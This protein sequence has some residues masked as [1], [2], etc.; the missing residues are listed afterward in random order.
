MTESTLYW[1]TR[2][3]QIRGFL[4]GLHVATAVL[5][6][7]GIVAVLLSLGFMAVAK[8]QCGDDWKDDDD[9]KSIRAVFKI[10]CAVAIPSVVLATLCALACAFTPTTREMVVIKVIPAIASSEQASKIV[11]LS[12]DAINLASEWIKNIARDVKKSQAGNEFENGY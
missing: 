3:D 8:V 9:Y 7:V 5:A 10:A 11:D 4:D 1:I 2:L 12:D 6:G